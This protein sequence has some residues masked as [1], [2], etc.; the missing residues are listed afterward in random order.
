M[1]L[2]VD[3][4]RGPVKFS[5]GG[6]SDDIAD[7]SWN[8]P[9]VVLGYP[10]NV[11]GTPGHSWY[12]AIAMATPVA[13]KGVV[14]GGKVV[15]STVIDLLTQPKLLSDAWEYFKN[16]QNKDEHYIPFIDKDTPPATFLNKGIM[17]KFRPEMKKFYYDPSK[18]NT[19]LEQLGVKYPQ[20]EKPADK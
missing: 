6:G 4:L 17:D 1:P 12:D 7:I 16:V 8:V 3:S 11:P 19:Y 2:K 18:Y 5:W 10:S 9:T 15:A 13:H 20:I 14:A